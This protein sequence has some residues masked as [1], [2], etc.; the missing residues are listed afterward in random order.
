MK[1][2][3]TIICVILALCFVVVI[4]Y[5]GYQ[6]YMI[7]ADYRQ[8]S[9]TH[10]MVMGFKPEDFEG[11][12]QQSGEGK[13]V[14]QSIIDLQKKHPDAIGW[15]TMNNTKIDYPIVKYTDNDYYLRRDIN[16][17]SAA[18][19]SVFMDYRCDKELT[20]QNTIIYGH[21]MKNGSMFG[22]LKSFN[23]KAFFDSN[24]YGTVYLPRDR[25]E[26]EFFAYM[27]INPS[28]EKEIYNL[29]ISGTYLDYVKNNAKN[30]RDIGLSENDRVV[31]LST[32]AYE[33]ADARMVLLAKVSQPTQK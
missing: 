24:R 12:E 21:H 4:A 7:Q 6:I 28:T 31:T 5:S 13:N 25:L 27:V 33:F 32:C 19:G 14:N 2:L 18:A 20:S 15:L 11:A 29:E 30:Y 17:K 3:K 1:K 22:T 10:D 9:E 16:G 8:E 26:L 23:D